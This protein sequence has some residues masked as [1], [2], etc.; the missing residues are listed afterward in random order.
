MR[1]EPAGCDRREHRLVVALGEPQPTNRNDTI[2]YRSSG[3]DEKLAGRA[4]MADS[5]YRGNH[6]VIMPYRKPR[7]GSDLPIWK[8]D[9]N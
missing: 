5:G 9:H 3:I 6:D 8:Q 7:D 4:V 2:V 1:G